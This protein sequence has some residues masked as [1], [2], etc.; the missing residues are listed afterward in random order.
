MYEKE[1]M[2]TSKRTMSIGKVLAFLTQNATIIV[3]INNI[4]AVM[5]A[6]RLSNWKFLYP[7]LYWAT[8]QKEKVMR[9]S[10]EFL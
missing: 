6:Q 9:S 10:T 2:K 4:H 3:T 1:T 7:S 8:R 5:M